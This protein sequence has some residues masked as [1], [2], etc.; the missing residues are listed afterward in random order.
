MGPSDGTMDGSIPKEPPTRHLM[1]K[2]SEDATRRPCWLALGTLGIDRVVGPAAR[3]ADLRP[4]PVCEVMASS[5]HGG[6]KIQQL[7][8]TGSNSPTPLNIR[9]DPPMASSLQRFTNNCRIVTEGPRDVCSS[10]FPAK[11]YALAPSRLVVRAGVYCFA[12]GNCAFLPCGL[13][14]AGLGWVE[15]G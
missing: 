13:A 10:H 1:R 3:E 4:T 11:L 15:L 14:C 12:W 9:R 7:A 2:Y 6:A 8:R 5:G